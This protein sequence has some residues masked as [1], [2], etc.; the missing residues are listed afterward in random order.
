LPLTPPT[1]QHQAQIEAVLKSLGL[2]AGTAS[3]Q[4]A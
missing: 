1:P 2:L 4:V 3:T